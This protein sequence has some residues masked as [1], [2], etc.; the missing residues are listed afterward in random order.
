MSLDQT[1]LKDIPRDVHAQ[2]HPAASQAPGGC[3]VL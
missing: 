3:R 1:M 2:A